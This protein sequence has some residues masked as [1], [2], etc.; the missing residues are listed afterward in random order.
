MPICRH[1]NV[2]KVALVYTTEYE[3]VG[4]GGMVEIVSAHTRKIPIVACNVCTIVG[5]ATGF[6]IDDNGKLVSV[7]LVK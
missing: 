3:V 2:G 4:E 5:D 1:C 6:K 7:N